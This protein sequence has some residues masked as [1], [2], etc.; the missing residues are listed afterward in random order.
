ML[1]DVE[2]LAED[3]FPLLLDEAVPA[4]RAECRAITSLLADRREGKI[5][6]L[7]SHE[8]DLGFQIEED[9]L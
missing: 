6:M 1:N 4:E 5:E 7:V 8:K 3:H 2:V 9:R